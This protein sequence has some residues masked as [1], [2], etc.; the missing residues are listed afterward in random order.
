MN[1]V[2]KYLNH[3][4]VHCELRMDKATLCLLGSGH[5]NKCSFHFLSNPTFFIFL[6]LFLVILPFKI[7]PQGST[8]VLS[9][10]FKCRK[11]VI[12]HKENIPVLYKAH[13]GMSYSTVGYEFQAN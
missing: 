6:C 4:K 11:T 7:S 13:S 8:Q 3:L 9:S 2:A 1:R 10:V 12:C 5:T